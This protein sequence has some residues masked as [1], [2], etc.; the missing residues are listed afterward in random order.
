MFDENEIIELD[1]VY[2][3]LFNFN[4]KMQKNESFE[5]FMMR[6]IIVI[7]SMNL[8]DAQLLVL[9]RL[10]LVKSL[11]ESTKYLIFCKSFKTF[12]DDVRSVNL[13]QQQEK[14]QQINI[15][16]RHFYI[17]LYLFTKLKRAQLNANDKCYKCH[18]FE[19]RANDRDVFCKNQS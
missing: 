19:H 18:E 13:L 2:N 3:K 9:I 6:F 12:V 1:K 16:V 10:K 7:V 8:L 15:N 4:F 5:I 14:F 11:H 17:N